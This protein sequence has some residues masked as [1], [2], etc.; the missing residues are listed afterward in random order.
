MKLVKGGLDE[1][2]IGEEKFYL[3]NIR[4]RLDFVR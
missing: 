4:Y 1:K 3:F 2:K